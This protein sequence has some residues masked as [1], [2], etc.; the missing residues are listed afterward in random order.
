[1]TLSRISLICFSFYILTSSGSCNSS[2]NTTQN[3]FQ[4]AIPTTFDELES[5][6]LRYGHG[7]N[8]PENISN[9]ELADVM[10]GL[11]AYNINQQIFLNTCAIRISRSLNMVGETIPYISQETSS[12]QFDDKNIFRVKVFE[13]YLTDK[14][15]PAQIVSSNYADFNG[16]T[17]IILFDMPGVWSNATGHISLWNGAYILGGVQ[18][19]DF[20]FSNAQYA[21]LWVVN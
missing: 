17:G 5:H 1:M 7:V 12:D 18:S 11:V 9:E 3:T 15:G 21:K 2:N 19:T 16:F 8:E 6:Y 13:Q 10:G 14:Y 20:H 4:S